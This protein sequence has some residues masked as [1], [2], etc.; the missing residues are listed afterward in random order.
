VGTEIEWE[1]S[2]IEDFDA[3]SRTRGRLVVFGDDDRRYAQIIETVAVVVAQADRP[4]SEGSAAKVN[5][6]GQDRGI[7]ARAIGQAAGLGLSEGRSGGIRQEC[8]TDTSSQQYS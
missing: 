7:L 4:G 6:T 2:G 1:G 8:D 5:R 3:L